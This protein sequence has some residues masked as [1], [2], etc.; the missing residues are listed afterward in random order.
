[1]LSNPDIAPSASIN[2]WIVSILMFHFELV[3]VPGTHHGPDGLSRRRPQKGDKPEPE[4][5]FEDWVDEVNGFPHMILSTSPPSKIEQPPITMYML[6][7]FTN[8][9]IQQDEVIEPLNPVQVEDSQ[10]YDLVP[11]SELAQ[12]ADIRIDRVRTWH[13]DLERPENMKDAEYETFMRYCTE[14]F[15]VNDRLWRKDRHGE[16]KLVIPKEKRLFIIHTAHDDTGHHGY[17]ATNALISLRY[18]WPFMGNDIAWFLKTCHI[19][20]T[21]KTQNVLIPPTVATPAPLFSKIYIDTMHMPPSSGFKYIVQGRCSLVH[22]PEFDM[23][24]KENS[25]AIAEWL[26]RD[27]IYRWGTLAEIV[28]NNGAPF[29]KA[30]DYLGKKYHIRH[31]RIS[32]YNSKANGIVERSH[33]DVRQALFKAAQGDASKWS[34][35]AYSVFWADRVTVQRR[36]GCSPYF[37]VTGTHPLLP[38]DISEASYLLPPP[39]SILSTTDLI[40]RRAT[41]GSVSSHSLLRSQA[42]RPTPTQRTFGCVYRS[43]SRNGADDSRRH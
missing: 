27:F 9:N 17:F 20:Q 15:V 2:R 28:T 33:F 12:K 41:C 4:D 25:R 23:L 1:M 32:G 16:H 19:C 18:W 26:L 7:S 24:R 34:S 11:R 30:L 40:A 35:V 5:D 43:T 3:H 36:M 14:F 39:D 8:N 42:Y 13:N 38:F 31:I 10:S 21:R 6:Q 22:Y 29:L 37:A